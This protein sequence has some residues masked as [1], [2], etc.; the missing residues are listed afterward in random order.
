MK[1][2][3]VEHNVDVYH[4]DVAGQKGS[5][6]WDFGTFTLLGS[7]EYPYRQPKN[8]MIFSSVLSEFDS[9]KME[10]EEP[11][12]T[13]EMTLYVGDY[14]IYAPTFFDNASHFI[15]PESELYKV[16]ESDATKNDS[17]QFVLKKEQYQMTGSEIFDKDTIVEEW[18]PVISM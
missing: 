6:I 18:T 3:T 16:V 14:V 1:V 5:W 2:K 10:K 15:S 8:M 17:E 13:V 12:K 9:E 4:I 11:I 7:E